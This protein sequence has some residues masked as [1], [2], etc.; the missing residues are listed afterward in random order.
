MPGR[1]LAVGDIH[2]CDVA[3]ETLLSHV[4]ITAE[5]TVVVLGDVVDR[6]PDTK[7]TVDIL[8]ELSQSCRLILLKGNHEEM[9]F[10]SMIDESVLS[11]WLNFGGRETLNSY[12]GSFGRIPSD[13]LEFLHNAKPF[14]ET[15]TT[16][17]VHANIEPGVPLEQQHSE[18]LHW[19]KVAGD[20]APRSDGR[21]VICGHT[22]QRSGKPLV[23]NG[24]ACI[25]TWIYGSGWLTCLDLETGFYV[26]T[27]QKGS[28]RF[29]ELKLQL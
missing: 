1:T 4:T 17:F 19:I 5:D 28:A 3:L 25:D 9:L 22:A 8:L 14:W 29:G 12:G 24:W 27:R 16:V 7:R 18:W 13:H 21:R 23:W 2:G 26:Q 11:A 20:E 6:G 15:D 10:D